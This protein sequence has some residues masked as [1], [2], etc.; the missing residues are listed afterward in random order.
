MNL[1]VVTL[2]ECKTLFDEYIVPESCVC[3]ILI[4]TTALFIF[5]SQRETP[6]G[7]TYPGL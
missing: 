6:H 4:L 2:R 7:T 5:Y 1:S 3:D